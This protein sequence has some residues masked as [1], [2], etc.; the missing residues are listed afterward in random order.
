MWERLPKSM[1]LHGVNF[2]AGKNTRSKVT[3]IP[4]R[5]SMALLQEMTLNCLNLGGHLKQ[6]LAFAGLRIKPL[7][8]SG[9]EC[10]RWMDKGDAFASEMFVW[11]V[12]SWFE[13]VR[14]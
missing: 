12:W 10:Q 2:H 8:L 7:S 9:H 1:G 13:P 6:S 11:I 4:V 14:K 5:H 3:D